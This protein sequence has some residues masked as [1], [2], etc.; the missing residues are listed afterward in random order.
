[1]N[2]RHHGRMGPGL[3]PAMGLVLRK[4]CFGSWM[5]QRHRQAQSMYMLPG[6]ALLGLL[7]WVRRHLLV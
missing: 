1:M 3:F 2:C 7:R 5:M 6:V 4:A